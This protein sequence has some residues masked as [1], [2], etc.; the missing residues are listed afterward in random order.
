MNKLNITSNEFANF[1]LDDPVVINSLIVKILS[2]YRIHPSQIQRVID[3]FVNTI[4]NAPIIAKELG[5]A[6]IIY[7]N[8]AKRKHEGIE[9]IAAIISQLACNGFM[10]SEQEAQMFLKY[11]NAHAQSS[12]E[13]S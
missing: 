11:L 9:T 4:I 1:H 12:E 6:L 5:E 8:I 10:G 2:E 13:I 7:S 3:V